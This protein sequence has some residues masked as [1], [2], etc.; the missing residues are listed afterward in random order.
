MHTKF[1]AIKVLAWDTGLLKFDFTPQGAG[2][3]GNCMTVSAM[4]TEMSKRQLCQEMGTEREESNR[5][6]TRLGHYL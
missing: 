3:A 4:P 5:T 2:K 1:M 6:W